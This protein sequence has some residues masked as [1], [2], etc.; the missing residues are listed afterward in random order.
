MAMWQAI[1]YNDSMFTSTTL[2]HSLFGTA[3][4]SITADSPLKPFSNNAT[5][6]FYTSNDVIDT[7]AFGYTYPEI[8]DWENSGEDLAKTV[9]AAVNKMYGDGD[10]VPTHKR[11]RSSGGSIWRAKN[12]GIANSELKDYTAEIRVDRAQ[13][14]LPCSIEVSLGGRKVGAAGLLGMPSKGV[15]Y[16]SVSLRRILRATTIGID[17]TKQGGVVGMLKRRIEVAVRSVGASRPPGNA[18]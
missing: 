8:L 6:N 11:R 9:R 4:G 13:L 15:A 10:G 18:S 5:G 7:R 14:A 12:R 3:E 16:V 2:G 17:V 1:Y